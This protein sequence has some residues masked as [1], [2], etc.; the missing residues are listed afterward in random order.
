[1][2]S[3]TKRIFYF[4]LLCAASIFLH[5]EVILGIDSVWLNAHETSFVFIE[6]IIWLFI[7][8]LFTKFSKYKFFKESNDNVIFFTGISWRK[9]S[10]TLGMLLLALLIGYLDGHYNTAALP[11]NQQ[12]INQ[13]Y[14]Q[15]PLLVSISNYLFAPT[16][17][18]LL[19][20]GLFFKMFF[21]KQ[22]K[23][24]TIIKIIVSGIVFGFAHQFVID[25]NWFI[26]C[27]MGW[28]L[29]ITY[30]YTK[31]LAYPTL[32]HLLINLM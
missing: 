13:Y 25:I 5:L 31:E 26:Y 11:E 20:R 18:E 15:V 29:G 2:V 16:V 14:L 12:L 1:M 24:N 6:L 27:S 8:L 9:L 30:Q 32:L 28:L 3:I 22:T 17:E 4:S 23:L 10:F 7:I 19:F 21:P